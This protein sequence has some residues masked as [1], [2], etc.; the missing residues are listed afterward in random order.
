MILFLFAFH[1]VWS[2]DWSM[3][4]MFCLLWPHFV[5]IFFRHLFRYILSILC[6]L[7]NIIFLCRWIIFLVSFNFMIFRSF[8]YLFSIFCPIYVVALMLNFTLHTHTHKAYTQQA[9]LW[10]MLIITIND[11]EDF[12]RAIITI[13]GWL[14]STLFSSLLTLTDLIT[15]H[16]KNTAI[17]IK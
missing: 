6:W 14:L 11:I 17:H 12:S 2:I 7:I 15:K 10:H 13:I 9:N 5:I 16:T 8:F 1:I 3:H 4:I